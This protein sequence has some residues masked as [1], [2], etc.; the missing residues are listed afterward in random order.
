VPDKPTWYGRLDAIVAEIERL[1]WP[2][3]D[4][5]TVENLLRVRRR[6]AQQ[7][8]QPCIS[9]Q[10]GANGVADKS[11]FIAYLRH[12]ANGQ[13]AY[14][15][16]RRREKLAETLTQ[17]NQSW[18]QQPKV[19]VEAPD[20]I[21]NAALTGLPKGVSIRPGEITVHFATPVEALEKLLALAMAIG[22]D[23]KA[24]EDTSRVED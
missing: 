21:V 5:Q 13:A 18:T 2:W 3:I 19:L 24:F 8:L 10:I 6:R 1:P 7:I 20:A 15:E 14:Y 22:N 4:R 11:E 23:I 9:R 12:L 17:L 16:R